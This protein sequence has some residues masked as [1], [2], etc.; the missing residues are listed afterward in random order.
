MYM[1]YMYTVILIFVVI[2]YIQGVNDS[3]NPVN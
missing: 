2:L 3:V 1:Y